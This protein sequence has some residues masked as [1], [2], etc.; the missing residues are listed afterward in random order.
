MNGTDAVFRFTYDTTFADYRALLRARQRLGPLGGHGR[1]LRYPFVAVLFVA[2]LWWL[3]GLSAPWSLYLRWDVARWIIGLALFIPLVDL[4][5]EHVVGRWVYSRYAA[6]NRPVSAAV[7]A[8]GVSWDVDAWSGR[9]AWSGV[10]NGVVTA[11]YLFL[12]IGKLEAITLPRRGLVEGDWDTVLAF[13]AARL[14]KPP[15]RG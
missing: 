3:G 4:F 7:D 11:D 2:T 6:A 1:W 10:K 13:V 12:F 9:F 8:D 15:L 5:F 14:P